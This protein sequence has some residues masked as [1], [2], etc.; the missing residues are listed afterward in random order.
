[1]NELSDAVSA[2]M[3]TEI[4]RGVDQWL[5]FVEAHQQSDASFTGGDQ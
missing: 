2:D 5:W 3:L 4:S 1:M